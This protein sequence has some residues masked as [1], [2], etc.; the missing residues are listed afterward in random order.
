MIQSI[1]ESVGRIVAKLEELK[2]TE[3]TIVIFSSDNGGVGGYATT[4]TPSKKKVTPTMRRCAV[5][6]EH[7]TKVEF[8]CRSL[9]AGRA[10]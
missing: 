9:S 2:L 7:F 4:E 5:V 8:V 10:W 1:D 6:R 3:N